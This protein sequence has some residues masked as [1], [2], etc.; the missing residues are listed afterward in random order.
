MR[1]NDHPE[2]GRWFL[3]RRPDRF[4]LWRSKPERNPLPLMP[5]ELRERSIDSAHGHHQRLRFTANVSTIA[6][7]AIPQQI[8]ATATPAQKLTQSS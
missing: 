1:Q 6:A 7:N 2:R 8:E 4:L 3:P 5:H